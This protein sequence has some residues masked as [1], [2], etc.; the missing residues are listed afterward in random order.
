MNSDIVKT[1]GITSYSPANLRKAKD[2]ILEMQ[3]TYGAAMRRLVISP[4]LSPK[5]AF[6]PMTGFAMELDLNAPFVPEYF[7]SESLFRGRCVLPLFGEENA[8]FD[9]EIPH[10]YLNAS[11]K[12]ADRILKLFEG[13]RESALDYSN[14]SGGSMKL[15]PSHKH[16]DVFAILFDRKTC[17]H[18]VMV[19]SHMMPAEEELDADIS[20]FLARAASWK[21]ITVSDAFFKGHEVGR[22]MIRYMLAQ[23]SYRETLC[24]ELRVSYLKFV[25]GEEA[26]EKRPS[27]EKVWSADQ[28][29]HFVTNIANKTPDGNGFLYYSEMLEAT[30]SSGAFISAGPFKPSVWANYDGANGEQFARAEKLRA[31]PFDMPKSMRMVDALAHVAHR[32]V[33]IQ[34]SREIPEELSNYAFATVETVEDPSVNHIAHQLVGDV[35]VSSGPF[36]RQNRSE[37]ILADMIWSHYKHQYEKHS[38]WLPLWYPFEMVDY[39]QGLENDKV[40]ASMKSFGL[41]PEKSPHLSIVLTPSL[42]LI[43]SDSPY[44][45]VAMTKANVLATEEI[46]HADQ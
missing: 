10:G 30:M 12:H 6:E 36:A 23:K 3:Q 21:K 29:A 46:D 19:E 24:R 42:Y 27:S 17:S 15:R 43:S 33:A 35:N 34:R 22:T 8:D 32:R 45:S 11:E 41:N 20:T 1:D 44:A 7:D 9:Q 5:V 39:V 37:V 26:F 4:T 18:F 16:S 13:A 2:D 25:M 28:A 31:L 40:S 38:R 14:S